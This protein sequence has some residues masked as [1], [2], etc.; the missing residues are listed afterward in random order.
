MTAEWAAVV[1]S[2]VSVIVG[3]C[4]SLA[5]T[6]LN[7]KALASAE[8]NRELRHVLHE[9]SKHIGSTVLSL[10]VAI[11]MAKLEQFDVFG[12]K[13]REFRQNLKDLSNYHYENKI[14]LPSELS[15]KCDNLIIRFAE[16]NTDTYV[17][18][19]YKG[20]YVFLVDDEQRRKEFF[21]KENQAV[22]ELKAMSKEIETEIRKLM[23]VNR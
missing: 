11:G 17:A 13:L 6:F 18:I 14:L 4:I 21:N 20:D 10:D 2:L 23:G 15:T 19:E 12:S 8:L 3:A 1:A 7:S 16:A 5:I 9:L 22:K